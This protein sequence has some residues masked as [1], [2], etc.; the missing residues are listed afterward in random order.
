VKYATANENRVV[1]LITSPSYCMQQKMDG[2]RLI[3]AKSGQGITCYNKRYEPAIAPKW[4]LDAVDLLPDGPWGFDGELVDNE[5]FIFDMTAMPGSNKDLPFDERQLALQVTIKGWRHPQIHKLKT[6]Y[7][8]DAKFMQ[9]LYLRHAGAEGVIL[10]PRDVN[11]LFTGQIYKYKFYQSVDAVVTDL[12]AGGKQAI[13]V[14]VFHKGG[15]CDIGNAK[16]DYPTQNKMKTYTTVVEIR[17]RGLSK[18]IEDGGRMIEPVFLRIRDDKPSF[19]CSSAQLT[20]R[21]EDRT[22]WIYRHDSLVENLIGVGT[23]EAI[24]LIK[25]RHDQEQENEIN[26]KAS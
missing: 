3:I 20:I 15:L 2:R 17:H 25:G 10:R 24:E 9:L 4:M 19:T 16:V 7:D 23:N 8:P 26:D 5:Y 14:A 21:G 1:D 12:K 11:P 18:D 22:G 13:T 6:W